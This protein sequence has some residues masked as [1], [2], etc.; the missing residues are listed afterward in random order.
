MTLIGRH[1]SKMSMV[2]GLHQTIVIPPPI[3]R[4]G[5][6][7][8]SPPEQAPPQSPDPLSDLEGRFPL[9]VEA[10]GSSEGILAALRIT[11]PMG[12]L[13]LKS[14]VSVSQGGVQW[15]QVANDIVVNEKALMGSRWVP[16]VQVPVP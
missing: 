8:G 14:T 15:A 1:E 16:G 13:A 2:E 11:R 5:E 3:D 9:V 6:A 12:T 7:A 4:I 10:S